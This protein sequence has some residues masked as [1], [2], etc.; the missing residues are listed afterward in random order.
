M[1]PLFE[2]ILSLQFLLLHVLSSM[3]IRMFEELMTLSRQGPGESQEPP[4]PQYPQE[5]N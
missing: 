1:P 3:F 2:A 4:R 5:P